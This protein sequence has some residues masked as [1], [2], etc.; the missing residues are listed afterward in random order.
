ML[1]PH[2]N[3]YSFYYHTCNIFFFSFCGEFLDGA[4]YV[5]TQ[6]SLLFMHIHVLL[7]PVANHNL[8]AHKPSKELHWQI[9]QYFFMRNPSILMF[10]KRVRGGSKGPSLLVHLFCTLKET[11]MLHFVHVDA[12]IHHSCCFWLIA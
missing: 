11:Q 5:F 12:N 4:V 7:C 9:V 6:Y 8:K 3:I 2:D 10:H 1:L